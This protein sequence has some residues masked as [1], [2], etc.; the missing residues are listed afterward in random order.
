MAVMMSPSPASQLPSRTNLNGSFH[1]VPLQNL[2]TEGWLELFLSPAQKRTF[3]QWKEK[4]QDKSISHKVTDPLMQY[5]AK[6]IPDHIAPNVIT[7]TGFGCLG[8]AWYITN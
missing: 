8:Q 7:L 4:I 3:S 5:L 6:F 1:D 2:T